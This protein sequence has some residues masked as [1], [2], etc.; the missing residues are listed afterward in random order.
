MLRSNGARGA[1]I[2][3]VFLRIA[4]LAQ[5]RPQACALPA[6]GRAQSGPSAHRR[7]TGIDQGDRLARPGTGA[8][9]SISRSWRSG[10]RNRSA[11]VR[12]SAAGR[13]RCHQLGPPGPPPSSRCEPSRQLRFQLGGVRAARAY[14]RKRGSVSS[15]GR[16]DDATQGFLVVLKVRAEPEPAVTGRMAR[17]SV[18]RGRWAVRR[19]PSRR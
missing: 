10:I 11:V 6:P 19:R 7:Q 5:A 13:A 3:D 18:D 15:S 9:S 1:E 2:L 16:P 17:R 4:Q 12:T 8:S 14:V